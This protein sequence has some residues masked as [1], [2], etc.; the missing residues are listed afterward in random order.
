MEGKASPKIVD[1]LQKVKYLN[2][3]IIGLNRANK[4]GFEHTKKYFSRLPKHHR[5]LWDDGPRL[6]SLDDLLIK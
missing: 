3:I 1:G 5:I 4:E 2:K 6:R